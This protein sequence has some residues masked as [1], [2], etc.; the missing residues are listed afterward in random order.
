MEVVEK[1]QNLLRKDPQKQIVFYFDD[2]ALEGNFFRR[3][4]ASMSFKTVIW[5]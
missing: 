5:L 1:I 3:L 4:T 2:Q